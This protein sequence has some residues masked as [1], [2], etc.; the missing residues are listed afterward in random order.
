MVNFFSLCVF[1]FNFTLYL[2]QSPEITWIKQF[3]TDKFEHAKSITID[4]N[5]QFIYTTGGTYGTFENNYTS[6]YKDFF[7]YKLDL[8]KNLI[9]TKQFGTDKDDDSHSLIFDSSSEKIYV[10]GETHGNFG[11][12]NK[13]SK[14]AFITKHNSQGN[15]EWVRQFGSDADDCINSLTIDTIKKDIYVTGYTKGVLEGTNSYGGTDAF[16]AKY[17]Q[18]GNQKWIKQFGTKDEDEGKSIKFDSVN[19]YIYV[20]GT[21]S[22]SL[23][24]FTNKGGKDKF[25]VKY[26]SDGNSQ[27][28]NQLGTNSDD[29]CTS[30]VLDSNSGGKYLYL[31]EVISS[32]TSRHAQIGKY[33]SDG[34]NIWIKESRS[35]NDEYIKSITLSPDGKFI[36]VSGIS[37]SL[38]WDKK[39]I[40]LIGKYDTDGKKIWTKEFKSVESDSFELSDEIITDFKGENIYVCGLTI[41]TFTHNT[42]LGEGDAFILKMPSFKCHASCDKC[43]SDNSNDYCTSCA[44]NYFKKEDI[45]FPTLCYK[46]ETYLEGYYF[47]DTSFKKCGNFCSVCSPTNS[48]L[49][50]TYGYLS[51]PEVDI[52]TEC[53]SGTSPPQG[54]F[55][56]GSSLKKCDTSCFECSSKDSC[57][58]CKEGYFKKSEIFF[59]TQ[60]D[61]FS[62]I[63]NISYALRIVPLAF[64]KKLMNA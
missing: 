60:M 23:Q 10:A 40:G 47:G 43:S 37:E 48:C 6:G 41:G 55:F 17:D 52:P 7:I 64:L 46:N 58:T 53:Y 8:N 15:I 38:K 18:E 19:K 5:S 42:K 51:K 16:I 22:G 32:T 25:L 62:K 14:D 39:K 20:C 50:C 44:V 28:K 31:S 63:T 56:D 30:I 29:E 27:W 36:Y 21:T 57:T 3:G 59:P 49:T 1:L 12:K 33:D 35:F 24:N 11:N 61:I 45:N 34:K 9:W 54:Y 4:S 13:G 2:T 26:N